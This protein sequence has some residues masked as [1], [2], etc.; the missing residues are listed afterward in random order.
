MVRREIFQLFSSFNTNDNKGQKSFLSS[1]K[2]EIKDELKEDAETYVLTSCGEKYRD[3]VKT[4]YFKI[5]ADGINP[6]QQK[7]KKPGD[8]VI[9]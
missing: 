5:Q 3:M 9:P 4:G 2:D 8:D 6:M 1:I 7:E